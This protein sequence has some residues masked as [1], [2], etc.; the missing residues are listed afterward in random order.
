MTALFLA[1]AWG[2]AGKV[3]SWG[4]PDRY[5]LLAAPSLCAAYF[6]WLLYGPEKIRDQVAIAFAITSLVALPFNLQEGYWWVRGYDMLMTEME[7]DLSAGLSWQELIDKDQIFTYW[8]TDGLVEYM[9]ML[10]K[11]KIGPLGRANPR[12]P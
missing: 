7:E 2:R 6:T 10:H 12:Q 11:A 3:P 5:A 1:L 9:E 8:T 4:M